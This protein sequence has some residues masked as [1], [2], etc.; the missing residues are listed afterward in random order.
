MAER[1][2]MI[3]R[4]HDLPVVRQCRI[5]ERSRST[6]DYQS[7]PVSPDEFTRMRRIDARHLAYPCAGA[8]MLSRV[9]TR[10][11]YRVGRRQVA[12]LMKWMGIGRTLQDYTYC[13]KW[14]ILSNQVRPPLSASA[15]IHRHLG[16]AISRGDSG[17][18]HGRY[19]RGS[20][21]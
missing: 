2:T 1:K 19:R 16:S 8:R 12:T 6:A 7:S 18:D 20:I 13:K 14:E 4:T 11:G 10:E 15:T 3:N 21:L 5:L 17:E 9:L